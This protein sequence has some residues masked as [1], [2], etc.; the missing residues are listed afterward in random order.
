M[1]FRVRA[2]VVSRMQQS[3]PSPTGSSSTSAGAGSWSQGPEARAALVA[4]MVAGPESIDEMALLRHAPRGISSASA[5]RFQRWGLVPA[6]LRLRSC[7]GWTGVASGALAP[8]PGRGP[9][10]WTTGSSRSTTTPIR[11]I[12]YGYSGGRGLKV[13]AVRRPGLNVV[14]E[15]G[16]VEQQDVE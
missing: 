12:E 3:G 7:T 4:D 6:R 9:R 16:S 8:R 15:H 1:G 11:R 10:S 14:G 5:M 2:A 13:L